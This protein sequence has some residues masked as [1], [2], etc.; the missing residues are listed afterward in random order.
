MIDKV[1]KE[2]RASGKLTKLP[3]NFFEDVRLYL[4]KK[5]EAGGEKEVQSARSML[6]EL[7]E[8]RES[9]ILECALFFA[10]EGII[11]GTM[12]P[13]ERRLFDII[14]KN[15]QEFQRVMDKLIEGGP[16]KKKLVALLEDVPE[17]VG[18]NAKPY[19]PFKKGDVATLPEENADLLIQRKVAKEIVIDSGK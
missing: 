8:R 14:V 10:R 19:G 11:P 12:V 18:V 1:V 7:R 13:E 16:E 2:Q 17:L 15:V 4:S 3:E 9:K 6:R 5:A